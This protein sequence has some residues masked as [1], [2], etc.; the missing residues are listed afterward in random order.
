MLIHDPIG[1]K[2]FVPIPVMVLDK[3]D[4]MTTSQFKPPSIG[5]LAFIF[6]GKAILQCGKIGNILE[7]VEILILPVGGRIFIEMTQLFWQSCFKYAN[8]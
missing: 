6:R 1:L 7:K 5:F 3:F 8:T 2:L 4:L